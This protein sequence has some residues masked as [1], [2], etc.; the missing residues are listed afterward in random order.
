MKLIN[1]IGNT[2]LLA[3]EK[4]RPSGQA[5]IYAKAEFMNPSGSVKD[6][7]AASMIQDGIRSG[8][9]VTGKTI[10][11]ATSGNTGI[12]Y[13]MLGASLG[14]PVKL[15]LPANASTERKQLMRAYGAE[16]VETDPLE[17]SDGA[18]LAALAEYQK[19]PE[20]YFYP[21][22]YNNPANWLAHFNGT[23]KEIYGQTEG[24]VT[25][26]VASTGTSGTLMG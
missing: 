15:Y 22:Q 18:Y 23:G 4:I 26:F 19:S 21:D 16:I 7:A 1:A 2:P 17:G 20:R 24:R 14:F 10:L 9:L 25:H 12:A 5:S 11:D 13:A 6:R 3:L 8:K